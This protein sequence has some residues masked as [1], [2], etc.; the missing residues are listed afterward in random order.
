VK[1]PAASAAGPALLSLLFGLG[2]TLALFLGIAHYARTAPARPPPAPDD[3]AVAVPPPEPPPPPVLRPAAVP[4]SLPGF[5]ASPSD[6]P[7]RIAASPP[8]PEPYRPED[9]S[10]IPPPNAHLGALLANYRPT[11]EAFADPGHIYS[12]AEVDQDPAALIRVV[13]Q[14]GSNV[15]GDAQQLSVTLLGV[16]GTGGRVSDVRV[17]RSSGRPRFDSLIVADFEQWGFSPAIKDGR[18]VR[19]LVEQVITVR[20]LPGSPFAQ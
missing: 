2:F 13:P 14:V 16:V 4:A 8:N 1:T 18:K 19:C 20:N 17:E 3:L 5:T 15:C 10:R 11:M 7:V 9:L 12:P 6:S